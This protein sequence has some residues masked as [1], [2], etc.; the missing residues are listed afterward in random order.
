[1]PPSLQP[2]AR[3]AQCPFGRFCGIGWV[4]RHAPTRQKRASCRYQSLV[5]YLFCSADN[6][7]SSGFAAFRKSAEKD[8]F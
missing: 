8:T 6:S 7:W 1:M 5:F 2:A 4:V 3:Y